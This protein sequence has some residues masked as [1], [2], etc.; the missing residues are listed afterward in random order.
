MQQKDSTTVLLQP[1]LFLRMRY[2][3]DVFHLKQATLCRTET[4]NQTSKKREKQRQQT[5][6]KLPNFSLPSLHTSKRGSSG[7]ENCQDQK[8]PPSLRPAENKEER[9]GH[10]SPSSPGSHLVISWSGKEFRLEEEKFS[11]RKLLIILVGRGA[12]LASATE[13]RGKLLG[14]G[15]KI[16]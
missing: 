8:T 13:G 7:G 4:S 10:F 3:E 11:F 1:F 14:A 12:L 9:V 15:E 5:S 6:N 2:N 16:Q